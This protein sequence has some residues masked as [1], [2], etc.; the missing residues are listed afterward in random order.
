MAIRSLSGAVTGHVSFTRSYAPRIGNCS[1]CVLAREILLLRFNA[2]EPGFNP[3]TGLRR[4]ANLSLRVVARGILPAFAP[5]VKYWSTPGRATRVGTK[6]LTDRSGMT[7]VYCD[8]N[9]VNLIS[10]E[11]A[12]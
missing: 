1:L 7:G 4:D 9:G 3:S 2:F 6:I 5:F 8:E 12:Q 10:G 11:L